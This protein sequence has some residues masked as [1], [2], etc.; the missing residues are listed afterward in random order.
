MRVLVGR[1]GTARCL[2]S[3]AVL[4]IMRALGAIQT[5]RASRVEPTASLSEDAV[6][7][8]AAT[9]EF[10]LPE[11]AWW[12]DMTLSGGPVL[13]PFSTRQEALEAE[14]EW[15]KQHRIA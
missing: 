12:A 8:L 7:A 5:R 2:Y 15:L 1:D 10:P 3:E 9:E 14:I 13:G 4:P 11:D 6:R